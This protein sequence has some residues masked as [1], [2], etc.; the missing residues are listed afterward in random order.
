M[1]LPMSGM[2]APILDV[3]EIDKRIAELKSVEN[4]LTMNLNVLRM[5]IQGLELQRATLAAMQATA[6]AA[7]EAAPGSPQGGDTL[8]DAWRTIIQAQAGQKPEGP[9]SS[10]K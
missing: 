8:A 2:V 6:A 5:S 3:S 1:G 4:W 7:P 9:D 10:K